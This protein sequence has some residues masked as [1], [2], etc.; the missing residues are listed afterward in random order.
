MTVV[1][2]E[3]SVVFRLEI[4]LLRLILNKGSKEHH[5]NVHVFPAATSRLAVYISFGMV[6][7]WL[8]GEVIP[9]EDGYSVR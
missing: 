8:Q 4:L 6:G 7:R 2:D 1:S 5:V 3:I 9:S